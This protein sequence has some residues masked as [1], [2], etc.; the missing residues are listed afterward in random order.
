MN[1]DLR[2]W[3]TQKQV[4]LRCLD[5]FTNG[6]APLQRL[7]DDLLSLADTFSNQEQERT[8]SL[9]DSLKITPGSWVEDFQS[10]AVSVEVIFATA[11]DRGISVLPDDY[12]RDLDEEVDQI[13]SLL[14]QL[15]DARE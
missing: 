6:T 1:E 14:E 4:A 13:R 10:S 15:P 12:V 3:A 11:L 9:Q 5:E 7:A 2:W 8:D